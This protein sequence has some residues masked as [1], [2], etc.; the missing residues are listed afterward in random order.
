MAFILGRRSL[1]NLHGVH[2]DLVKVVKRAIEISKVDF[3]V[4]EGK[5]S[6]ERQK[7]LVAEGASQTL[8]GRHITGHA[9][10]LGAWVGGALSWN[11]KYYTAISYAMFDAAKELGIPIE[12]GGR[13]H[14]FKDLVHFQL[15]R[16]EYP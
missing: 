3:V 15:P 12:W 14:N 16:K 13:W 1:N 10:D 9:V 11:D 2:P 5:R 6:L 8:N 7:Q 4:I